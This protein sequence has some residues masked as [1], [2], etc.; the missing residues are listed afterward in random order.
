ML[1]QDG[2]ACLDRSRHA[3][4]CRKSDSLTTEGMRGSARA[5]QL[6]RAAADGSAAASERGLF[7][8]VTHRSPERADQRIWPFDVAQQHRMA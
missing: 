1:D 7:C 6:L 2:P 5:G 8:P 3:S 4:A